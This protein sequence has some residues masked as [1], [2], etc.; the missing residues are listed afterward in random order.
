M[1][2][3]TAPLGCVIHESGQY[4]RP[5]TN[6]MQLLE[7]DKWL[8]A[9]PNAQNVRQISITLE[10]S[11]NNPLL[12]VGV[13]IRPPPHQ[14]LFYGGFLSWPNQASIDLQVRWPAALGEIF[15]SGFHAELL[16]QKELL[17]GLRQKVP[18]V[19]EEK[20]KPS[21]QTATMQNTTTGSI[22][23]KSIKKV[24]KKAPKTKQKPKET[25]QKSKETKK[26]TKIITTTKITSEALQEHNEPMPEK[27]TKG[28]LRCQARTKSGEQC[29]NQAVRKYC[30]I[31]GTSKKKP[32][33]G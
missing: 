28:K 14:H 7:T 24:R 17:A 31:H 3:V 12:G 15:L 4:Q 18:T 26:T 8:L 20:W 5:K 29:R 10:Q 11:I 23:T 22:E 1:E 21:S 6:S 30:R 2:V 33:S 13:Y 9:I 25:K 27:W 19:G 16:F 32:L